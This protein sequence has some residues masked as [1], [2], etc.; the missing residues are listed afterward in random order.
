MFKYLFLIAALILL[1]T[2][3]YSQTS[4]Y[5][6]YTSSDAPASSTVFDILLEVPKP[7]M[8]EDLGSRNDNP[9]GTEIIISLPPPCTNSMLQHI[10]ENPITD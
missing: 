4:P 2:N 9:Q 3:I 1:L 5:Y 6:N 10:K 7:I 8:F